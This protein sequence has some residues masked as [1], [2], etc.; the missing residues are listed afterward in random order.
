[1]SAFQSVVVVAQNVV[2]V[3]GGVKAGHV[4]AAGVKELVDETVVAVGAAGDGTGTVPGCGSGEAEPVVAA[5][6]VFVAAVV[7]VV[8]AAAAAA[9]Q[10]FA[11]DAFHGRASCAR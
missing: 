7:V 1:M 8:V 5:V 2:A 4:A 10:M 6:E 11:V 9:G 3:V